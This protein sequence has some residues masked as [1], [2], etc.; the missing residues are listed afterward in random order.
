MSR[1][2]H[3]RAF[4]RLLGGGPRPRDRFER[5]QARRL[6][7]IGRSRPEFSFPKLCGAPNGGVL[8]PGPQ[9]FWGRGWACPGETAYF[10]LQ[11]AAGAPGGRAFLQAGF[12]PISKVEIYLHAITDAAAGPLCRGSPFPLALCSRASSPPTQRVRPSDARR[13]YS[14]APRAPRGGAQRGPARRSS[15]FAHFHVDFARN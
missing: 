14:A 11:R 7:P 9:P 13:P 8:C 2:A 4:Q 1:C 12:A 15:A 3:V 10:A 6:Q 5:A